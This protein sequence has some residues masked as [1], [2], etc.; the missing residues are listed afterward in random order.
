MSTKAFKREDDERH[1]MEDNDYKEDLEFVG[2]RES[3][4]D[5]KTVQEDT[6]FEDKNSDNLCKSTI[7]RKDGLISTG[8]NGCTSFKVA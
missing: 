6:E 2:D 3:Q 1:T 4:A 8:M 7:R 5:K